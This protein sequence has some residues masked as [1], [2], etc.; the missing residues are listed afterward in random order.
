MQDGVFVNKKYFLKL[1]FVLLREQTEKS[2]RKCMYRF[3]DKVSRRNV[4]V[5]VAAFAL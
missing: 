4:C 3:Y 5:A 2:K 1:S